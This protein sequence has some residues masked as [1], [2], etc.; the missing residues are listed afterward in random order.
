MKTRMSIALAAAVLLS[1]VTAASAAWWHSSW[2]HSSS[3]STMARAASDTF[4]L[5]S[6][7]QRMAWKD[8]STEASK[9]NVPSGFNATVGSVVPSTLKIEPVPSKAAKDVPSLR[10]YDFAMVQGKLLIVNPLDKKIVEVI[11][12]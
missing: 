6:T 12:G 4:S 2:W 3:S 9:Q 5:N 10:P 1:G 8:L 7:G 11:T